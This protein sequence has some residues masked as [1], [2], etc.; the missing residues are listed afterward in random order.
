L[1][2]FFPACR[3]FP[4]KVRKK[5]PIYIGEFFFENPAC[6]VMGLSIYAATPVPYNWTTQYSA[7][8][9]IYA[10]LEQFFCTVYIGQKRLKSALK[11]P[12]LAKN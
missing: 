4:K 11:Y 7:G 12:K 8:L 1:K 9:S 10:F 2:N 6:R 5:S 3:A